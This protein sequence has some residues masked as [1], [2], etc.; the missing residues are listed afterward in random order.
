MPRTKGAKQ[1]S[2]EEVLKLLEI[3]AECHPLARKDWE[4]TVAVR[5]NRWAEKN[6]LETRDWDS[7]RKK[8]TI[9]SNSLQTGAENSSV[10]QDVALARKVKHE[11]H[12]IARPRRKMKLEKASA[13][14]TAGD[15]IG[16][17]SETR[18]ENLQV[19][20]LEAAV[21][22][23][24]ARKDLAETPSK[25]AEQVERQYADGP[26]AAKNV[27]RESDRNDAT[28]ST[29]SVRAT[30]KSELPLTTQIKR[31]Q[32]RIVE[33]RDGGLRDEDNESVHL[34]RELIQIQRKTFN[35]DQIP[36]RDLIVSLQEQ[37]GSLQNQVGQLEATVRNMHTVLLSLS[38]LNQRPK[39]H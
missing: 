24:T 26:N 19:L 21:S 30:D 33:Q 3:V 39:E 5:Y 15:D 16:L 1:Y 13:R 27:T 14:T 38:N 37:V 18:T 8:F 12:D 6:G 23:G 34:L 36:V 10:L 20:E 35:A 11:L 22:A 17:S 4:R 29:N 28:N 32:Q 31:A 9:L 7:L 2:D 25:S